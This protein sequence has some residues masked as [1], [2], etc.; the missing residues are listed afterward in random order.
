MACSR[1]GASCFGPICARC[2]GEPVALVPG[3]G[4]SLLPKDHHV[5]THHGGSRLVNDGGNDSIYEQMLALQTALEAIAPRIAEL[6]PKPPLDL[7][8]QCR[9]LAMDL[10]MEVRKR[11]G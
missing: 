11:R 3:V 7:V 8:K 4:G 6:N 1:C 10:E 5:V 9:V 2:K